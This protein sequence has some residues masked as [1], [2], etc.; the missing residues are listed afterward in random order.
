M[1]RII[2]FFISLLLNSIV[3]SAPNPSTIK[4]IP[5]RLKSLLLRS[6]KPI[7]LSHKYP[8]AKN[9]HIVQKAIDDSKSN[10]NLEIDSIWELTHPTTGEQTKINFIT[11]SIKNSLMKTQLFSIPISVSPKN[12]QLSPNVLNSIAYSCSNKASNY[13]QEFLWGKFTPE[14]KAEVHL[15]DDE[16][17][18]I[19]ET[20]LEFNK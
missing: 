3:I 12:T 16:P 1:N 17:E 20:L 9:I 18:Y 11:W 6:I 15:N 2:V 5:I 14:T 13:P 8:T 7:N 19:D 10:N 4:S